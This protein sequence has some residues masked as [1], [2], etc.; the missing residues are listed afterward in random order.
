MLFQALHDAGEPTADRLREIAGKEAE[1]A[2]LDDEERAIADLV[3]Q[4]DASCWLAFMMESQGAAKQGHLEK[5]AAYLDRYSSSE[6]IAWGTL[7]ERVQ[8]KLLAR[9]INPAGPAASEQQQGGEPWWRY[10]VPPPGLSWDALS[11][12]AAKSTRERLASLLSNHLAGA[13]FDRGG[14][15]LESV[16]VAYVVPTGAHGARLGTDDENARRV[17]GNVLRVLGQAK[18]FEGQGKNSTST[19]APRPL[20][21]YLERVAALLQQPVSA[22]SEAVRVALRDSGVINDNWVIRTARAAGLGIE[23]RPAKKDDLYACTTCSKVTAIVFVSHVGAINRQKGPITT[24][25]HMPRPAHQPPDLRAQRVGGGAPVPRNPL[26]PEQAGRDFALRSPG[27][28]GVSHPQNLDQPFH[29]SLSRKKRWQELARPVETRQAPK[30]E[31]LR[32]GV[33]ADRPNERITEQH[34]MSGCQAAR[35]DID[36]DPPIAVGYDRVLLALGVGDDIK[37]TPETLVIKPVDRRR[38]DRYRGNRQ[39]ARIDAR[40]PDQPCIGRCAG[41]ILGESAGPTA[42]SRP[43]PSGHGSPCSP[44][45]TKRHRRDR[46]AA[47]P[48]SCRRDRS[49]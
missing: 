46:A 5:I 21:G 34:G 25:R 17:L 4:R 26:C 49:R 12:E 35:F 1:A 47:I 42:A 48:T 40:I 20:R 39:R 16:G 27:A 18:Y 36:T 38:I 44:R 43:C 19:D 24:R 2:E 45:C 41:R 3:Q 28:Q 6:A 22:F 33:A 23:V 14:R 7:V 31:N 11:P 30:R 32:F 37:P 29:L 15:D 10:F 9:G 13:L 8:Q